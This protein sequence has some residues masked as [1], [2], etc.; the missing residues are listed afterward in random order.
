MN[1]WIL[2]NFFNAIKNNEIRFDEARKKQY[3][4]L[5]KL[6]S[7]KVG[8]KQPIKKGWLITLLDFT[9][10]KKKLLIFLE[11]MEKWSL[12]Q[13]TNQNKIKLKEQSLKY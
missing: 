1:T 11:I 7:I 2:K 10:L 4:F 8:K 9:I 12:M 13:S 5:N 6:S 3:K